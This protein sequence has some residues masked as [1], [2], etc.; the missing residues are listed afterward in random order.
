MDEELTKINKILEKTLNRHGYSF[1]YSVIAHADVLF[2]RMLSPWRAPIPEFPVEIQGYGTRIDTILQHRDRPFF[3]IIETKRANPSLSN[4]CFLKT[5]YPGTS[6]A[7]GFVVE[8]IYRDGP[9][10]YTTLDE[11]GAS[12]DVCHLGI[13]V[14]SSQK[15]D[16]TSQG[17]GAIESAATQ[18]LRGLN[19][20]IEF[21]SSNPKIV[22]RYEAM[23]FLPVIVTTA[24]LFF[25][26][27]N[28][29]DGELSS[30]K[31]DLS[32][33]VLVERNW[34]IYNY[35]QSP[36]LKHSVASSK[37]PVEFDKVLYDKF[38]RSIPI[39]SP[40]GLSDFLSS[41]IWK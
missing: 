8:K 37:G 2:K 21:L 31:I 15:G 24:N 6:R 35:N 33:Q 10:R 12:S 1:Q 19:G 40:S 39:V 13:E 32:N 41:G 26:S 29:S 5:P 28:I 18:V 22:D 25:S 9:G 4:W 3:L 17:R 23:S 11:L 20:M 30:G 14:K 38:V 34:L 16:E 36:G 27:A 7:N